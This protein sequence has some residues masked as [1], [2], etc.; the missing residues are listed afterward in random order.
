[1]GSSSHFFLDCLIWH[2][3]LTYRGRTLV[4]PQVKLFATPGGRQRSRRIGQD[5]KESFYGPF[6]PANVPSNIND[7]VSWMLL[8]RIASRSTR[9]AVPDGFRGKPYSRVYS[10][11]NDCCSGA[12]L[13]TPM[14]EPKKS[15]VCLVSTHSHNNT[16]RKPTQKWMSITQGDSN[17]RTTQPPTSFLSPFLVLRG[18][19]YVHFGSK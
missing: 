18:Y 7:K 10:R 14:R 17:E 12:I 11:R 1:M 13:Q 9:P 16:H 19:Y 4:V 15:F 6:L 5:F 2:R 3:N 8:R